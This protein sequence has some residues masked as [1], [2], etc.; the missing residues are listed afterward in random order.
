M[1][2]VIILLIPLSIMILYLFNKIEK[3]KIKILYLT[4][5]NHL[6]LKKINDSKNIYDNM[7]HIKNLKLKPIPLN[8]KN[9]YIKNITPIKLAPFDFSP[10]IF[11]LSKNSR[12]NII[13]KIYIMDV[14]WYE[15]SIIN[16]DKNK[17]TGWV[18]DCNINFIYNS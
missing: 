7:N 9:V 2:I 4:K 8:I 17:L 10:K 13:S 6:L 15:I 1:K 18:K 11:D 5:Q 16:Q 3:Q 14:L 12:L